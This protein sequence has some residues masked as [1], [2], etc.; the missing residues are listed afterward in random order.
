LSEIAVGDRHKVMSFYVLQKT[1]KSIFR[2]KFQ[3]VEMVNVEV[4]TCHKSA[5][6][7]KKIDYPNL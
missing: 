6:N 1:L 3:T 2:V 7:S 4:V 5:T